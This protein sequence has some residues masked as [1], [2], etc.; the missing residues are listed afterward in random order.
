[1]KKLLSTTAIL[2]SMAV[3]AA[4]A[5][6]TTTAIKG[7]SQGDMLG[8]TDIEIITALEALGASIDEV[9]TEDGEIEVEFTFEG[10]QYEVEVDTATG[11]IAEIEDEDSDADDNG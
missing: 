4:Y 6:G 7:I 11:L 5:A 3:A 10:N 2:T 9:E 8:K 1:M